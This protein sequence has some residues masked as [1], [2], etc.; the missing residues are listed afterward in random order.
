LAANAVLVFILETAR[1][2]LPTGFDAM[3]GSFGFYRHR[4]YERRLKPRIE[5][6]IP[7]RIRGL[8]V[9]GKEFDLE[10]KLGNLSAGGLYVRL[11]RPVHTDAALFTVFS[12]AE[13]KVA[14]RCVVCR[15]ERLL[16]GSFGLGVRFKRYRLLP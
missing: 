9:D 8:D 7:A 6:Y 4:R 13:L 10:T 5:A 2:S 16:D 12:L 3:N 11:N 1:C 14:A 15:T